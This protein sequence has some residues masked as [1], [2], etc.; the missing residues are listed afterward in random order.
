VIAAGGDGKSWGKADSVMA[1]A[2][3][4]VHP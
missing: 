1:F 4:K 2:L 3:P